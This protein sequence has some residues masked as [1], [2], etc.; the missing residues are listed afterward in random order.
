MS[1]KKKIKVKKEKKKE[2]VDSLTL[3]VRESLGS[4]GRKVNPAQEKML[5]AIYKLFIVGGVSTLIDFILYLILCLTTKLDPMIINAISFVVAFIYGVW[6][7][8]K[9]IFLDKNKKSLL[10]EFLILRF[11]DLLVT[12]L[13]LFGFVCM[14]SWNSIAVKI[15]SIILAVICKFLIKKFILHK[16]Q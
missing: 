12:E 11:V 8:Y 10:T 15:L 2:E 1:N 5:V 9:F 13:L 6:S 4:M 16:K 7:S 14:L 3:S